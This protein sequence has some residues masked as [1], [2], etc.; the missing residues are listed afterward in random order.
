MDA[1]KPRRVLIGT[2]CYD[3]K[4]DVWYANS[5]LDTVKMGLQLNIEVFPIYLSY[6]ALIQRARN[7]LVALALQLDCDDLVFIDSDIEWHAEDFYKLLSYPVDVVGGTYPKKGDAEMYV[8]K[9]LDS[10]RRPDQ[11]GLIE[12]EGLGTGFLRLS[13]KALNY[14]WESSVPYEEKDSGKIRRWIFD[15]IVHEGELYSEDI[16]VCERLREGGIKIYLDPKIT[17]NHVGMK[18]YTGNFETWYNKLQ[19]IKKQD[20]IKALYS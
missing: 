8:A 18:K 13:R 11:N 20:H 3:G 6:D 19:E 2:P 12:A 9:V 16:Y 5:M 4:V 15:V 7:D 17:C 14:L 1:V 10:T